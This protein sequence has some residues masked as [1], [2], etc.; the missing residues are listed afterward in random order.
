MWEP[1]PLHACRKALG[2]A[3]PQSE[4]DTARV[5]DSLYALA[6]LVLASRIAYDAASSK[7]VANQPKETQN[8]DAKN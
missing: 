4:V 6:R 3:T 2:T 7:G 1:L 8:I 5:R